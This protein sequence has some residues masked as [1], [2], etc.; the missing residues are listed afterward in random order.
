MMAETNKTMPA[1]GNP[2][3]IGGT[4]TRFG[5][6]FAAVFLAAAGAQQAPPPAAAAP[7]TQAPNNPAP[8]PAN[9]NAPET[10]TREEPATFKTRVN[11][12]M[13]P[14]VVRDKQ[15][16]AVG[17]LQ[18]ED[19][20]L[21]DKGKP[22]IITKFSVEK[23]GGKVAQT[24]ETPAP[25]EGQASDAALPADTPDR[26]VAYLFDDIH[27]VPG[28]LIRV[29]ESAAR[30]MNTLGPTD[31]AAIYTTSGQTQLE[32]TDD[33][34]KLHE[35]LSRLMPRPIG[36]RG[37]SQ[38]PDISY[39]MAD[40][41]VNKNDPTALSV[42]T[43]ET[44][45]CSSMDSTM[46]SSAQ[47]IARGAAQREI[48]IG[49]QETRVSL[50][51]IKDLIRRMSAMPG[52]RTIILASPGFITNYDVQQDKTDLLD[53]AIHANVII[54][55]V[56]ARGLYTDPEF[57]ASRPSP[58]S[59]YTGRM[60]GNYDRDAARAQA[61]VLAELAMGT[62]GSFFENNNDLAAGFQKVAAPPEYVYILGF[63]PQNLK[64]DGSFH[65]LKVNLKEAGG[66]TSQARKGYYAP[67]HLSDAQ[68]TAKAELQEA[69]FS[70]EEM[71]E[72]PIDLHTQY[73][74]ASDVKASVTV[75]THVDLRHLRLRKVEGRN[76][77]SLTIVSA[78]FDRNGNYVIG[79]QKL[80]ELRLRDDTLEKRVDSGFSVRSSFDV[81]PGTYLIRLVVRDAEGQMMSAANGAVEIP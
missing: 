22:Q 27:L 53:R 42:A 41:I 79:N 30:H 74:K 65:A 31:R 45:L 34:D 64:L 47:Q 78:L 16:H 40:L 35:T 5:C 15:G 73:F 39:Y 14:V 51:V 36:M 58:M 7:G 61:D 69:I 1:C 26:F 17:G 76:H 70:R 8:A 46:V 63:S 37:G 28:D 32:F 29:R 56:D 60:K 50:L 10:T 62:G 72:L 20:Q 44:L 2:S 68:E 54:S 43:Q 11:L 80:V 66:L 4:R 38:C 21:F 33:R 57:D 6:F 48:S 49:D 75:I 12:V 23:S 3:A 77:N 52:Q 59:A 18:Q 25:K 24:V 13:V 81:K 19:F 67:K 55:A 71:H 9:P